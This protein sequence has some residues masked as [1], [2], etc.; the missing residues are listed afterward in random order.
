MPAVSEPA[1]FA[2]STEQAEV[3]FIFLELLRA[4]TGDGRKK[5]EAGTKPSWKI[6]THEAQ[7][8]SHIAKWK[9]GETIDPDS[10]THTLVHCAWRC[11]AIA[12]QE[13]YG[14]QG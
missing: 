2:W 5:R 3:L 6:D 12:W 8:F 4:P 10:G 7:I 11:L 9:K 14:G 13:M 1:E